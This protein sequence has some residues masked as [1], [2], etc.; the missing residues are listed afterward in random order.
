LYGGG[1]DVG[2]EGDS[3]DESGRGVGG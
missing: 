3:D 2:V 1:G